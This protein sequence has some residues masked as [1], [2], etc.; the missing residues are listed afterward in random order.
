MGEQHKE[1][2]KLNDWCKS[3]GALH[4]WVSFYNDA[5]DCWCIRILTNGRG[6]AA[7]LRTCHGKNLEE[8]AAQIL[9][10]AQTTFEVQ[11]VKI[12]KS[13]EEAA[14]YRAKQIA[15]DFRE[16]ESMHK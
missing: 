5:E 14:K 1:L 4:M 13:N 15:A 12:L 2:H 7:P 9:P 8:V 10:L 16:I 11:K 6:K 3:T